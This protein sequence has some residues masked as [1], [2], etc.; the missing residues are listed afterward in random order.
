MAK[1]EE[2]PSYKNKGDLGLLIDTGT[3]NTE[4]KRKARIELIERRAEKERLQSPRGPMLYID[5]IEK[6]ETNR[7]RLSKE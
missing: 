6:Q 4:M 7:A 3:R 1:A 2:S 5:E